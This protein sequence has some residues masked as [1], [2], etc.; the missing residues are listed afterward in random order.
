MIDRMTSEQ[1]SAEEKIQL[2]E[3]SW[4]SLAGN[5]ESIPVPPAQK[6]ELDRRWAEH[7]KNPDPAL[8]LDEFKRQLADRL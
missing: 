6:A 8:S 2:V 3:D 5:P 1:L 7:Q 4:D